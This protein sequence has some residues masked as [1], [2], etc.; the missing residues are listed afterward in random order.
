MRIWKRIRLWWINRPGRW[1][2]EDMAVWTDNEV[3]WK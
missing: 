3:W 1:T 2:D